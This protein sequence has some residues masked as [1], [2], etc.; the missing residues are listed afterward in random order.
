MLN[1]YATTALV[2][3]TAALLTA[4]GGGGS[5]DMDETPMT[6]APVP[7]PGPPETRTGA[8]LL[9]D[10]ETLSAHHMAAVKEELGKIIR[11]R[12]DQF[13]VRSVNASEAVLEIDGL[14]YTLALDDDDGFVEGNRSV[15]YEWRTAEHDQWISGGKFYYVHPDRE[16]HMVVV[17]LSG[18]RPSFFGY[19][20]AGNQSRIPDDLTGTATYDGDVQAKFEIF[21]SNAPGISSRYY[22]HYFSDDGQLVADFDAGTISGRFTDWRRDSRARDE[23]GVDVDMTATLS[24]APIT[25]DGFNGTFS[26]SGSAVE[27]AMNASY[28]GSFYGP[29]AENVAGV[30]SGT[31]TETGGIPGHVVGYFTAEYHGE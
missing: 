26:V 24:A 27:G 23:D 8:Q 12:W 2:L 21:E 10:G 3:S 30:I 5:G 22:D 6:P 15:S 31:F 1:R 18:S 16:E 17:R 19:A 4:C 25:A 9:Q 11:F 7:E 14:T 28:E 29:E 13:D 20:V